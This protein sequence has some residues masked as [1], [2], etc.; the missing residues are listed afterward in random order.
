[1]TLHIG[2][3][4]IRIHSATN[5]AQDFARLL[6]EA[7]CPPEQAGAFGRMLAAAAEVGFEVVT[8]EAP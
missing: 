7:G 5:T 8:V 1:M 2:A 3:L 4:T 6:R